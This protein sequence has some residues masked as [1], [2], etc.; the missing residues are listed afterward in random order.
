MIILITSM[1]PLFFRPDITMKLLGKTAL[2]TGAARGI[3]RGCALELARLERT[4][5]SMI[6]SA[7]QKLK[8]LSLKSMDWVEMLC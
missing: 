7:R 5:Q 8:H 2:V 6:E 3:G 4:L 1:V